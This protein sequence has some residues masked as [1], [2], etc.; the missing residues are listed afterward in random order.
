MLHLI[1]ISFIFITVNHVAK[2]FP[3]PAA[4]QPLEEPIRGS[5][6]APAGCPGPAVCWGAGEAGD[7]WPPSTV[8]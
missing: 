6:P 5:D 3:S 8:R 2:N 4:Y 7:C 1:M